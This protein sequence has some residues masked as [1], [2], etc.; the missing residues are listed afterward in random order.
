MEICLAKSKKLLRIDLDETELAEK[1]LSESLFKRR[2]ESPQGVIFT[3]EMGKN[4]CS[5]HVG[6]DH[7]KDP[8][9]L[10]RITD[11]RVVGELLV[12]WKFAHLPSA[13][14]YSLIIQLPD[15]REV[16]LIDNVGFELRRVGDR[17]WETRGDE[18]ENDRR[19]RGMRLNRLKD[20]ATGIYGEKAAEE[21]IASQAQPARDE[22]VFSE[23]GIREPNELADCEGCEKLFPERELTEIRPGLCLCPSCRIDYA[24]VMKLGLTPGE[25]SNLGLEPCDGCN[26]MFAEYDLVEDDQGRKLCSACSTSG[27]F[28]KKPFAKEFKKPTAEDINNAI[29]LLLWR[30][31]DAQNHKDTPS[32][33]RGFY[34][35]DDWI[36]KANDDM[37]RELG[38]WCA[39]IQELNIGT[40]D[41]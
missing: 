39:D 29:Q 20:G 30:C 10:G 17:A 27:V 38:L 1:E 18:S 37:I 8:E 2:C 14:L 4:G 5:L 3:F 9:V 7:L 28:S 22:I 15:G 33:K 36:A 35:L 25:L 23:K 24:T 21:F 31:R 6:F 26:E 32:G 34:G 16:E 19:S 13:R 12:L 11:G 41:S 40:R